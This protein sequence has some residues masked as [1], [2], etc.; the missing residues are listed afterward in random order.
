MQHL[1][2][3]CDLRRCEMGLRGQMHCIFCESGV[4]SRRHET[5]GTGKTTRAELITQNRCEI[6]TQ[7]QTA[8]LREAR[9]MGLI[10]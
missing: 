3:N 8:G 6:R 1:L 4:C 10:L 2:G 9:R 7:C 5:Y